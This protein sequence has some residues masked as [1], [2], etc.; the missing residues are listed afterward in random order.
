MVA[1]TEV[2][3]EKRRREMNKARTQF[4]QLQTRVEAEET[5]VALEKGSQGLPGLNTNRNRAIRVDGSSLS[6][7]GADGMSVESLTAQIGMDG[8]ILRLRAIDLLIARGAGAEH[9]KENFPLFAGLGACAPKP[10]AH[11]STSRGEREVEKA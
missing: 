4:L 3:P 6:D 9:P 5:L 11:G 2:D 1:M 8:A 10:P 7:Q